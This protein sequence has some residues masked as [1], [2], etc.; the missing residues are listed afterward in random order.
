MNI[1]TDIKLFTFIQYPTL[2]LYLLYTIYSLLVI[3][4]YTILY[5]NYR[6]YMLL[7]KWNY[8]PLIS[9]YYVLL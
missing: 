3:V 9:T 8:T 6:L 7:L 5:C 2:Q 1:H 4:L